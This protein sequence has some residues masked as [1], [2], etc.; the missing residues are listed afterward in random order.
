MP[1]NKERKPSLGD[2]IMSNIF[3]RGG[4]RRRKEKKSLIIRLTDP[5]FMLIF[6]FHRLDLTAWAMGLTYTF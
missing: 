5:L 6:D 1:D 2:K 3:P 4:R